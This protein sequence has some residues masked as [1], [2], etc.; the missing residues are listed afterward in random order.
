MGKLNIR[1]PGRPNYPR[2]DTKN[3]ESTWII[4]IRNETL[5]M[6]SI[7]NYEEYE[8]LMKNPTFTVEIKKHLEGDWIEIEDVSIPIGS[9]NDTDTDFKNKVNLFDLGHY[10]DESKHAWSKNELLKLVKNIN[11]KYANKSFPI[12]FK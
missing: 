11:S 9:I 12:K 2:R 4:D 7:K 6:C 3:I 5:D 1:V 8:S 10:Y